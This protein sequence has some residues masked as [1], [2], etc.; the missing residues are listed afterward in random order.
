MT[1]SKIFSGDLPAEL[2]YEVIKYF[3]NDDYS[4]LHSCLLVNRL[5]CR[6]AI[7]LLWENPFSINTGNYNF[8]EIYLHNLNDD[9]FNTKLNEHNIVNNSL[10][11]NLLFNYPKFLKYLN[12]RK[13]ILSVNK[14]LE[15]AIITSNTTNRSNFKVLID[16]CAT[17]FK[18]FIENKVNLHVLEIEN[19]SDYYHKCFVNILKLIL[20]N[21]EF[22]HN[23]RNIN[24]FN[25]SNTLDYYY[26]SQIINLQ[27]NL[28]KIS[29]SDNLFLY[30]S[31]LL[32][33]KSDCS[34]T[35]TI[36]IFYKV[37]FNFK[38]LWA[39]KIFERL[40]HLNVLESI[41]ILYCSFNNNFNQ[42]IINLTKPFK[43]KS[44]LIDEKSQIGFE[45]SKLLLQKSGDYLENFGLCPSYFSS[46]IESNELIKLITKY[47]K[48]INFFYFTMH[49]I[50]FTYQIFNLIEN[51]KQ[52]LNYLSI[53]VWPDFIGLKSIE[54]TPS[55]MIL[56]NLGQILPSKLEY[57]HLRLYFIK[58][59]DFEVFLKNSQDTFIK[60]LSINTGLGQDILPLIKNYIM[61]KKRVKYLAI[62]D[63]SK[64][65]ISLKEVN[66][67]KLY[68]IEVQRHS[69]LMIDLYDY[70][71]EIN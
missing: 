30:H 67:F 6:L 31:L 40:N 22:I 37:N 24:L 58:A 49:E 33:K 38:F 42:Q 8:I 20:K 12:I 59:S 68:N 11:S 69:D 45:S 47:C 34:N 16:I 60:K 35:L 25:V 61:K 10:L 2:T 18:I 13:F 44:L 27:Q 48:N 66:E 21:T 29:I 4:T 50:Q 43:L 51:I 71:K 52:N 70:I 9:D 62:N 32:S 28:K 55:S 14:W 41:H 26:I 54:S 56:Q 57:L 36:I 39:N 1:C 63:S 3:Q 5:W 46:M 53:D 17:I 19:L 15:S 65:L 23:I 7:P 64:E